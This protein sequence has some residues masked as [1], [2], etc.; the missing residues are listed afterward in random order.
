MTVSPEDARSLAVA[1]NAYIELPWSDLS[2]VDRKI[3]WAEML[4][5]AQIK[6]GIEIFSRSQLDGS[7]DSLKNYRDV[8]SA[9]T[10]WET[11]NPKLEGSL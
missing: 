9:P 11:P 3:M 5:D 8:M 6:C 7:I 10:P 2:V 1:Y 4:R